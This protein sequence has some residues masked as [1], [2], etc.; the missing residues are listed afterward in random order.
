MV[1]KLS[2]DDAISK[3]KDED[4]EVRKLAVN[5]LE[6]VT[7]E[8]LILP[9]IE[10]LNDENTPVKYKAAELLGA[11][12]EPAVEPLLEVVKKED[13]EYKRYASSALKLTA[14]PKAVEYFVEALDDEDWGVRKVAVRSLGEL[15]ATET[16]DR[17]AEIMMEEEDWGVRLAAIRS[18]GDME[19]EEAIAP[20]KKARRKEKDKDFKKAA[21]K[22]IKK[23]EK[24]I[25]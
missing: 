4:V 3:L 2:K 21:N 11:I 18:L 19:V 24:A 14:S 20:I 12:G 1:E 25:K 8:D 5:S 9:L 15:K 16:I 10:T 7:D 22:A 13:G 17:I 6:G 23:I